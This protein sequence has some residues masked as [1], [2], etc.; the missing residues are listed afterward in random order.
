MKQK[1]QIIKD[2][3]FDFSWDERKVWQVEAPV[4]VMPIT[5]LTWHFAVSFLY[6]RPGAYYDLTPAQVMAEPE[7]YVTEQGRIG[8]SDTIYPI[9]IMHWRGRWVILDGL[10]WLMKLHMEGATEVRVRKIPEGAVEV[11]KKE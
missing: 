3:G 5:E 1:P 10:H 2:L 4:E 11:I 8:R 9:D 6:S 7:R